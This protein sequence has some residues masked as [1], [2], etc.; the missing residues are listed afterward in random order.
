MNLLNFY[1]KE[2]GDMTFTIL[3]NSNK[4]LLIGPSSLDKKDYG[5]VED[6]CDEYFHM[7]FTW[8]LADLHKNS[9]RLCQN[10]EGKPHKESF[11]ILGVK[12]FIIK[13]GL[14]EKTLLILNFCNL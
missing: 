7:N 13:E 6:N 11:H 8:P 5:L 9:V 1:F 3:L 14:L 10:I 12:I 4:K 2:I